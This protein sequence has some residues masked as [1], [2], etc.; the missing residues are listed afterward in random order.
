MF[1]T[2]C[3]VT[4][5]EGGG[6]LDSYFLLSIL[7]KDL[8]SLFCGEISPT[9]VLGSKEERLDSYLTRLQIPVRGREAPGLRVERMDDRQNPGAQSPVPFQWMYMGWE[10]RGSAGPCLV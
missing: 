10:G 9:W 2:D 5:S 8:S 4:F 6:K 1:G 3:P 7:C